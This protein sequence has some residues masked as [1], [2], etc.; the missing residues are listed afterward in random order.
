[1]SKMSWKRTHLTFFKAISLNYLCVTLFEF[2]VTLVTAT[3]RV[4]LNFKKKKKKLQKRGRE[5]E[6][7]RSW[8][9]HPGEERLCGGNVPFKTGRATPPA[10]IMHRIYTL[11]THEWNNKLDCATAKETLRTRRLIVSDKY[12]YW[13]RS[14]ELPRSAP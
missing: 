12:F 13:T 5:T 8:E 6:V 10:L 2:S 14:A 1:M 9:M 7:R 3:L 11:T 4:S